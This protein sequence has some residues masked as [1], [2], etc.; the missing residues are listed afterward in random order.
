MRLLWK[1]LLVSSTWGLGLAMAYTPMPYYS[2]TQALNSLYSVE[3]PSRANAFAISAHRLTEALTQ[4]CQ[5]TASLS[6]ARQQWLDTLLRWD[7]LATPAVG[8]VLSGR[9]HRHID[10]WPSRPELIAKAV[11]R[12]P[13]SLSELERIGTPAKG[14]PAL[15]TLL[16]PTLSSHTDT[17]AYAV[18]LAQEVAQTARQLEQDYRLWAERDWTDSP[19]QT[20]SAMAEW[21]NQWLAGLE[22]LRWMHMEKP[23]RSMPGKAPVYARLTHD[24]NW[25]EWHAQ[26]RRLYAQAV[27]TPAQRLTPPRPGQDLIPIEALLLGKGHQKLAQQWHAAIEQVNRSVQQLGPESGPA[28]VLVCAGRIKTASTLFQT[29]I[30]AALDIPLGFSDADGD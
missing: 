14:L 7:E 8:P 3:L 5:G 22:K 17:C 18:L 29:E 12:S 15:E 19:E 20:G 2:A 16:T 11:A 9:T 26:W 30:A 25:Q 10:F 28:D 1:A 24:A 21:I 6:L 13:A 23:I 27:L 4:H